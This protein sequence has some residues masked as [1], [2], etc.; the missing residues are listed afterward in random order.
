MKTGSIHLAGIGSYLPPTVPVAHAVRDGLIDAEAAEAS[1]ITSVTVETALSATDMAVRAAEVA[2]RRSGHRPEDFAALLHSGAHYQGPDS[3]SA[4]HHVLDRTLGRPVTALE[5]RQGCL[6]MLTSLRLAA[7]LLTAEDAGDAVLVT[8]GDNFSTPRVDR[9]RDSEHAM[10]ADSGAALVVSRVRGF[11]EVLSVVSRSVP[12]LESMHRYGEPLLPPDRP[13]ERP[14]YVGPRLRAWAGRPGA[15]PH[16]MI[17][18][19]TRYGELVAET[20]AQGLAEAGIDR[21]D[22]ARVAHVGFHEDP[23]HSLLL[24]PV[25]IPAKLG[26]WEFMRTVGHASVSDPV[27][28][29]EHLWTTGQVTEGDHVLLLGATEGM[30]AGCAVVRITASHDAGA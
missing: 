15:G 10:Y 25:G 17:E 2:V 23:L 27:L 24:D 29:L 26:T 4:P 11:A 5:V 1:G 3:W 18:A 22:L 6:A 19:V 14:L 30:E 21:D 28:G 20:A 13:A 12:E 16:D 7:A 9:W 8:G